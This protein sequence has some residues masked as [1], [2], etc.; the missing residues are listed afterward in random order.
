MAGQQQ[1]HHHGHERHQRRYPNPE[2][3]PIPDVPSADEKSEHETPKHR[4]SH[5]AAKV[6]ALN[7]LC[8]SSICGVSAAVVVDGMDMEAAAK[9][10]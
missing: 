7:E 8:C 6:S 5:L 10:A 2:L 9:F 1:P 3:S 4:N